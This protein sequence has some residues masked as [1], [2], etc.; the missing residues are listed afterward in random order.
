MPRLLPAA[1]AALVFLGAVVSPVRAGAAPAARQAAQQA[2][3]DKVFDLS[4]LHVIDIV[5]SPEGVENFVQR[6][7]TRYRCTLTFDGLVLNDVGIRQ[8][9][10]NIH[11]YR[12]IG[13]KP[14]LSIKFNEFVKGQKLH[15]LEKLVLKNQAQDL[16]LVNEHLTYEV[17][18]RAGLAAPM[19]AHAVVTINGQLSGIYLMREP[20]NNEFMVRNFGADSE[21][22]NLYEFDLRADFAQDPRGIDLKDEA[23]DRRS[24]DDLIE[25]AAIVNAV[26]PEFFVQAVSPVLDVDRYLTYFAVEAVTSDMDGF[27]FHNNNSYLYRLPK[28]GRFIFI[29]HGA[30]ESFWA[31]GSAITRLSGPYH[32]PWSQLARKVSSVPALFEKYQAE[33]ARVSQAP[34]WDEAALL[35][36]VAQVGRI[37]ATAERKGRTAGDISRF[38]SNRKIVEDFIRSRGTTQGGR[39][40]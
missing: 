6:A 11:P 10:G 28:T 16:S 18:R 20:V 38:E 19:T 12:T 36:R 32:P 25:L 31:T 29:P 13:N 26:P 4:R 40:L 7:E 2:A 39:A 24:R 35:E 1:F 34:V 17:F 14:T 3:V 8:A 22:G 21:D 37:L 15:G 5:I 23:E 27:S 9:G 33:V 30:D